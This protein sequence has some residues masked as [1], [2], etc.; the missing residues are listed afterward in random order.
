MFTIVAINTGAFV[1]L[2]LLTNFCAVALGLVGEAL[3]ATNAVRSASFFVAN[4][5]IWAL[6][7]LVVA[8]FAF[9]GACIWIADLGQTKRLLWVFAIVVV[10]AAISGFAASAE[11]LGV[12][13]VRT[14][15]IC[16]AVCV[17]GKA[18]IV[19]AGGFGCV[20]TVGVLFTLDSAFVLSAFGFCG[21]C[22]VGVLLALWFDF[23]S[24][25]FATLVGFAVA[26]YL[27]SVVF[28]AFLGG[29][30]TPSF[31]AVV[32]CCADDINACTGGCIA[33]LGDI[34]TITI[35]STSRF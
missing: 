9:F 30:A 21:V 32:V 20:R 31:A 6:F 4:Q 10:F 5:L 27:A 26:I 13:C 28:A 18:A 7:L 24:R 35:P 23:A 14:V 16:K 29:I 34:G 22:A 8:G 19:F 25:E 1:L 12:V 2:D 33:A 3:F 11:A 17:G 15:G